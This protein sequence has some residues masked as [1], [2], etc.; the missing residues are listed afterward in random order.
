M[1]GG[2]RVFN[3]DS[4]PF[5]AEDGGSEPK[6]GAHAQLS[7]LYDESPELKDYRDSRLAVYKKN[8]ANVDLFES[9]LEEIADLDARLKFVRK[10]LNPDSHENISQT[11]AYG[12]LVSE[13]RRLFQTIDWEGGESSN[14]LNPSE[15][16]NLTDE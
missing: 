2:K 5:T 7:S 12:R 6:H 9:M 13:R 14:E 1:T 16:L 11:N 8:C 10:R 4:E 15:I 3:G